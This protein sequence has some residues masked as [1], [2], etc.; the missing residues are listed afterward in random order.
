MNP[1]KNLASALTL[2]MILS[3][4]LALPVHAADI[5]PTKAI[6]VVVPTEGSECR[7]V[8]KFQAMDDGKV[9]ITASVSGLK[10]GQEHAIH[11]HEFGDITD[12]SGKSAGGHFNPGNT[13]HGL[14]PAK[15]RHA[16]DLGNLKADAKGKASFELTVDNISIASERAILGRAIVIHALPDDGG[17]PTGNAGGRI[18]FGVIG[19]ANPGA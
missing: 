3:A 15:N 5:S 16:G 18:G 8:V 19:I 7:G 2:I 11:I 12:L 9:K 13:P 6:C 14:P 4:F 10:P 17:Q 1:V